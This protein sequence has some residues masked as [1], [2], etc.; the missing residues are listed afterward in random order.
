MVKKVGLL[1]SDF[2]TELIESIGFYLEASMLG[3]CVSK[4]ASPYFR[5][6]HTIKL[7]ELEIQ[8][9]LY[10]GFK[11]CRIFQAKIDAEDVIFMRD[12]RVT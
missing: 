10:R 8:K 5:F 3:L 1:N 7:C 6:S 9:S 4:K 2:C 12:R 11:Q